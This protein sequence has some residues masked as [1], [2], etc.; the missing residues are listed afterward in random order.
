MNVLIVDD[1]DLIRRAIQRYIERRGDVP[2]CAPD[3]RTGLRVLDE[4]PVDLVITD[5][6]MPDMDGFQILRAVKDRHPEV[7]VIVITGYATK[8]R[9]IQSVNE[10]AFALL[11]KPV[12]IE[13]LGLKVDEAFQ[14]LRAR[15]EERAGVQ[16]LRRAAH[17]RFVHLEKEKAFSAAI[18]RNAPLP[19][20]LVD[21]EGQIR[22]ANPAFQECFASEED[23][24]EGRA[25]EEIVRSVDL[26]LRAFQGLAEDALDRLIEIPVRPARKGGESR[27]F[28]VRGFCVDFF[29]TGSE[30]KLICLLM[31]DVTFKVKQGREEAA[32]QWCLKQL[33]EFREMT[34]SLASSEGLLEEVTRYLSE[35]VGQ[36][37][38][39][40]VRLT[41]RSRRCESGRDVGQEAPYLTGQ[42]LIHGEEQ[43]RLEFFSASPRSVEMQRE[44]VNELTEVLA[45]RIEARELDLQIVQS[46]RLTSLGEMAAGVAHELNQPLSGIRTFAEGML[47]G[48]KSGWDISQAD[49]RETFQDIVEQADRMTAI[50]DHMRAF[51]RDSSEEEPASF[52]VEEVV[53]NVFK[54]VG[55]QLKVHGV[56]VRVDIPAGLPECRGWPRQV[57]QVLLNLIVNARQAMDERAARMKSGEVPSDPAWGAALGV[58]VEREAGGVRVAISDT[59]GGIPEEVLPRIFEPFFT[60]K[61]AG[62]GTG[63]GL[64]ISESIV[65]RHGGRIEVTNRPGVGATFEVVLPTGKGL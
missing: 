56:T 21:R 62:Q 8:E 15:R 13:D 43:G 47:Y 4:Q 50:I 25:L 3:G 17:D 24:V 41:Y 12:L 1:E 32:R 53:Q 45:R 40:L 44:F 16:R 23:E 6:Q 54:L 39:V 35:G 31:Q 14:A 11:Q 5:I 60:S 7:P 10:G 2:L 18:L 64:S 65:Q 36:L 59:G 38:E 42:I 52:Q 20:C 46:G 28:Q 37:N 9:A 61:E 34:V 33:Y 49:L 63:L 55:S 26:D 58:R 19:I 57:E 30:G 48:L 29:G 51:S 22:M 27:Y